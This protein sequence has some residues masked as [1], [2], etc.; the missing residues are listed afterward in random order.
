M[1]SHISDDITFFDFSGKMEGFD[2][3]ELADDVRV[4]VSIYHSRGSYMCSA[5]VQSRFKL[6]CDRCLGD[7]LSDVNEHLDLI[8]TKEEDDEKDD[9]IVL[10]S[11]QD[12]DIDLLPY[13]RET[14]ILSI[15]FKKLCSEDCKG[16]CITCGADLNHEACTCKNEEPDPRWEKLKEFKKSLE[17]AEE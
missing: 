13:V 9:N 6:T 3:P 7:Y 12:I 17:S 4:N 11:Q 14:L 1:I 15:P 16:L 10:L 8:F 5:D 2:I